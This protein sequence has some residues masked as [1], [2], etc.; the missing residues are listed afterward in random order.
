MSILEDNDVDAMRRLC[1]EDL[2]FL[3]AVALKRGDTNRDWLFDRIRE[4]EARP[5]GHLD[6]WARE[7]YKSTIITYALT[8][9]D[10][11]ID[12]NVTIGIFSHTR[13]IA[14]KFLSQIKDELEKNNFLKGL[15]PDILYAAPHKEA[16]SWSLDNGITVKRSANPKEKTIEAWG[17][18]DGQPIGAH[19]SLLV[20]DDVVT[21]ESVT[22][23][24]Q[25]EKTNEAL[26]LSFN[27]GAHGGKRRFIG[28]RYHFADTYR[29]VEERAIAIPRIYAATEDGTPEG[30][31]VFLT[32]ES[33][34]EK[35]MSMGPYVFACHGAGTLVT[36]ADFSQ[37]SI[38]H[39]RVGDQVIGWEFGEGGKRA[40]LV[41][42][43]VRATSERIAD[44][45]EST[46]EDGTKLVHTPDH[47]WWTGRA[48][49]ADRKH[50]TPLG[51]G[52]AEQQ[53]VCRAFYPDDQGGQTLEELRAAAYLAGFFDADGTVLGKRGAAAFCQDIKVNAH[54]CL[55]IEA[56]L[57]LLKLP[58]TLS[59]S[60]GSAGMY[61]LT[62]GRRT[63]VRFLYLTRGL[64]AKAGRIEES[65]LSRSSRHFGKG[66]RVGLAGQKP[67]EPGRVYTLQT[68]TGNYIAGGFCSKNCQMLQNPVADNA[69]GFKEDWLRYYEVSP[70]KI[71]NK[72]LLCDPAGGKKKENDY[73]VMTVWGLAE[74]GN[75]YL[76]DGLRDRLN[77]TE[78]AAALFR[79]QKKH[80]RGFQK[81][82]YEKYG[83]Q[84][85]IE[86][87]KDKMEREQY[88]FNIQEV[89]GQMPKVDRIRRLVPL[90]ECGRVYLPRRLLFT[91]V[92][93]K[94][95]DFIQEFLR[96]EYTAF[97]VAIHDDML[98]NMARIADPELSAQFPTAVAQVASVT[99]CNSTRRL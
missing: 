27:L 30:K 98:D 93:G 50:Y 10:I 12:P 13:P 21:R 69:Q 94:C 17:L 47:K 54:I 22:T 76:V 78:R 65:I 70:P 19:F 26:A 1:R 49:R 24:E 64:L 99:K 79:L 18:V 29:M 25:I 89:G 75:Y 86:H 95:R 71:L 96:D 39:V 84:A 88:R 41:R 53:G 23:P 32:A 72:Y 45:V 38:E 58:W 48:P 16:D 11:L 7:H 63:L 8:I 52:K 83:M 35:R 66:E 68:D 46:L 77:L 81:C 82:G 14:K 2:F 73:T 43:T 62:G 28:T 15:Y 97:P 33:L 60:R 57:D 3:L 80:L 34:A 55:K 85:D 90:F 44:R 59:V 61:C 91:D 74:D 37:R 31:P 67:I 87:I 92:E 20:Y 51:Y 4:V 42:T 40:H 36:M 6:A 5:D 9:R 56:A